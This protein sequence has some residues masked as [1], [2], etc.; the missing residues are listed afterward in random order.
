V[1]P[2][3]KTGSE[4]RDTPDFV[5]ELPAGAHVFEE[6]DLGT[7]MYIIQEGRVEIFKRIEGRE[8][9]LAVFEKGDFFGEM[10]VLEDLPRTATA[11]TM[12]G[13]RLLQINGSTFDQMLRSHPEIAVRMM[14]KLSRRLRETDALLEK[15]AGQGAP[16]RALEAPASSDDHAA[17][18]RAAAQVLA[19]RESGLEFQL[20]AGGETLIGR[21]DPVTGIHP[22]VDLT[23]VD[24]H[25][26]TSRRHARIDRR[27]A[28]F[29]LT[30]EIGTTNGTFVNGRRLATGVPTEL[31]PGD[32]V[33]F[34]LVRMSFRV[35]A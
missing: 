4:R 20:A 30:E 8:S 11:R 24:S 29:F 1:K 3:F 25:R 34:G 32:E 15:L 26:S 27:G 33:Q 13:T 18:P 31:Q 28:R 14:R 6:G 19:H 7:E 16:E 22:D 5:V 21:Q 12:V 35:D 2:V 23:E 17:A 9:R 10:S